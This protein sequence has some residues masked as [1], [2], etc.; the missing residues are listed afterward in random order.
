MKIPELPSAKAVS[1]KTVRSIWKKI[2]EKPL[3]DVYAFTVD[4]K[5]FFFL[6]EIVQKNP[7][8]KD[9]RIKEYGVDFDNQFIEAFS[10]KVEGHFLIIIKKTVSLNASLKH[11]LRHIIS[12]I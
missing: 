2:S 1:P 8:M 5:D 11:E 10:F 4:E 3:P 6:L 12:E 9:T 7:S